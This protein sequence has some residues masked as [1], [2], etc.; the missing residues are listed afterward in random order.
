MT[1]KEIVDELRRILK[2]ATDNAGSM[3]FIDLAEG[4]IYDIE[5]LIE[6]IDKTLDQQ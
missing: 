3:N 2:T 1:A 6:R 4:L 5:G